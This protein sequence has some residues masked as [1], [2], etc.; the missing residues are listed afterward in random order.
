MAI[1]PQTKLIRNG[2]ILYAPVGAEEAVMMSIEAGRYFGLNAVGARIW[3]LLDTPKTVAELCASIAEE[4]E[5]NADACE[6][7][8]VKF[9]GHL[10]EN[11]I[12]AEADA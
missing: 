3:E 9:T 7:D 5:V 6:P 10:I 1:T 12:V 11:G 4:F 8:V 2:D